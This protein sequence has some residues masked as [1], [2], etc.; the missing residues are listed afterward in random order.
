ML[1]G[2]PGVGKGTFAKLIH[3][4]FKFEPFS[5]GDYFRSVIKRSKDSEAALD[6]FTL[7]ISQILNSG[8]L[9]DD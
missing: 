2:A 4:D 5:T 3:Q 6:P 9:V 7:K 1:F 8:Q